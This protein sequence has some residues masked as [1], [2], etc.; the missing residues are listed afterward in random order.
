MKKILMFFLAFGIFGC[1]SKTVDKPE[2]TQSPSTVGCSIN[3]ECKSEEEEIANYEAQIST[4]TFVNTT[5]KESIELI[6]NGGTAVFYYGFKTCPWCQDVI[7]YLK[8]A[9]D[10]SGVKV[11]YVNVRVDGDTSEFDLRKE[12]NP[13]YVKLQEIFKDTVIDDTGKIY[14]P[15][16]VAIK[17]GKIVDYHYSTVGD[18]NAKEREMTKEEI[19]TLQDIYKSLFEKYKN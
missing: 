4:D 10:N 8:E 12:E 3:D 9:A 16:V 15:F 19:A 13:E 2:T 6:E 18:H 7:N 1:T 11:N 17:D 5:M 14:V